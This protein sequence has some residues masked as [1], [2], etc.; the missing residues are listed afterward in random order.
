MT[1]QE[2]FAMTQAPSSGRGVSGTAGVGA[3][4]G[5]SSSGAGVG[6]FVPSREE[7]EELER[8]LADHQVTIFVP[9]CLVFLYSVR[10]LGLGLTC[11]PF[12][13]N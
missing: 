6:L 13:S 5:G 12:W 8:V 9:L 2:I 4:S 7:A 11:H 3:T 10:L 1:P